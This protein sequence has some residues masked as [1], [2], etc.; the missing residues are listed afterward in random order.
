MSELKEA[1][2]RPAT[3]LQTLRAVAWSFFGVRRAG[4]LEQDVEKLNPLHLVLAGVTGAVLFVLAL[5]L[6]V[7]WVLNSGVA[8]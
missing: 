2:R 1:V 7:R 3:P 5:L 8:S 6:L 4:G